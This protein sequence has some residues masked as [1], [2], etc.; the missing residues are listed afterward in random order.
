MGGVAQFQRL[1]GLIR[2]DFEHG[3]VQQRVVADEMGGVSFSSMESHADV[4]LA[5]DHVMV[6]H[7]MA[8]AG[9]DHPR[10]L[11]LSGIVA[12]LRSAAKYVEKSLAA[13]A[14]GI[15]ADH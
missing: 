10:T 13:D 14:G 4:F 12:D 7:H 9:D 1:E 8:L 3:D 11:A 5:G 6:G 2:V 15:D